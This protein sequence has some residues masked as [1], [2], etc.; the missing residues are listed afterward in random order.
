M[1]LNDLIKKLNWIL[2]KHFKWFYKA[3]QKY[4]KARLRIVSKR[5]CIFRNRESKFS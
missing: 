2:D 1:S 4:V 3:E 5:K